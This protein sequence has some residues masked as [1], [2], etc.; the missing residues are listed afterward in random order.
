MANNLS[1]N[2]FHNNVWFQKI[3]IPALRRVLVTEYSKVKLK[4][5][6]K[7]IVWYKAAVQIKKI[8]YWMGVDIFWDN[9][10]RIKEPDSA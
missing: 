3:P 5:N 8:Y 9:K 4:H 10:K 1:W 6:F 2:K 7:R